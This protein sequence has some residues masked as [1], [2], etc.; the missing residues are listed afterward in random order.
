MSANLLVAMRAAN[1]DIYLS[2]PEK[3]FLA[4]CKNK[5]WGLDGF[6]CEEL[7]ENFYSIEDKA[8]VVNLFAEARAILGVAA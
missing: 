3:H 5:E 6:S 8:E 2:D 7:D 4:S 1:G